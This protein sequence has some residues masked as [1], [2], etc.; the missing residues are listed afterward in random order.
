MHAVDPEDEE[1]PL[2]TPHT[3]KDLGAAWEASRLLLDAMGF[4][5]YLFH[6]GIDDED[7]VTI[8]VETPDGGAWKKLT[9]HATLEELIE[10]LDDR[11]R[12]IDL[13]R[14]WREGLSEAA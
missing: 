12:R 5:T 10:M 4:T 2:T 13:A 9:L 6:L 14:L 11:K 8:H 3:A 1:V 7:I